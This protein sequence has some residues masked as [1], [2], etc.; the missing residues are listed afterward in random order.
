MA[1]LAK[2]FAQCIDGTAWIT[3]DLK[4]EFCLLFL[5]KILDEIYDQKYRELTRN[6][7]GRSVYFGIRL[8]KR[9]PKKGI[10]VL[11][12]LVIYEL[13]ENQNCS[14][15]ELF[16]FYNELFPQFFPEKYN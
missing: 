5:N 14:Q 4:I 9:Y 11:V 12:D 15:A 3:K 1:L 2:T 16:T 6:L 7:R 10:E 13:V 8:L